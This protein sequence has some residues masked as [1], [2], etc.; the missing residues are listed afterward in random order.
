MSSSSPSLAVVRSCLDD[1]S[2]SD[3]QKDSYDD[4][5]QRRVQLTINLHGNIKIMLPNSPELGAE[6]T[7]G[8][9]HLRRPEITESDGFVRTIT[10]AE[11][12]LRNITYAR[13]LYCEMSGKYRYNADD[14]FKAFASTVL[15]GQIPIMT[16]SKACILSGLTDTELRRTGECADD[17]GGYF[18]VQSTG[19]P[20]KSI[21]AQ[22]RAACNRPFVFI[23]DDT[24]ASGR[25]VYSAEIRS[26]DPRSSR[27]QMSTLKLVREKYG[28]SI[29][30]TC[31]LPFIKDDIPVSIVL[32]ALG[33]SDIAALVCP[34]TDASRRLF[35]IAT[36][37]IPAHDQESALA[38]IG[39][40]LN[41]ASVPPVVR[42]TNLFTNDVLIHIPAH[43]ED[44]KVV[45]GEK[46]L[47]LGHSIRLLLA[48]AA[49]ERP[50]D[51]RDHLGAKRYDLAGPLMTSLF[52]QAF[53][54]LRSDLQKTMQKILEKGQDFNVEKSI[55]HGKISRFLKSSIATGNWSSRGATTARVGVTQ[56]LNRLNRASTVSQLRRLNAPS[57]RDG[58]MSKPRQLHSTQFGY[59]CPA[60]TPE[61]AQVG[62][63]KNM[64]L[65]TRMSLTSSNQG[66][67]AFI[68]E[69]LVDSLLVS[70]PDSSHTG[71]RIF[72]DGIWCGN[73]DKPEDVVSSLRQKR[74][75]QCFASDVS[76][77]YMQHDNLILIH[78]DEGR[79]IRPLFV[80][81]EGKVTALD[82]GASSTP[83]PFQTL[84]VRGLVEFVDALEEESLYIAMVPEHVTTEHTHCELHPSTILGVPASGIPYCDHNQAP[85]NT[86]Q[87]AMSKQAIGMSTTNFNERYDVKANILYYPQRP[88]ATTES[89]DVGDCSVCCVLAIACFSGYNQE[90]SLVLN[91]SSV[92]R[93]LF[94][95]YVLKTYSD[96]AS[97]HQLH[98]QEQFEIPSRDNCASIQHAN[99]TRLQADGIIAPGERVSAGDVI[100]GKTVPNL[101]VDGNITRRDAST[102]LKGFEGGIVDGVMHTTNDQGAHVVKVRIR[103]VVVPQIGDKFASRHGQKGTVGMLYRQEDM[104]FTTEGIVPDLIMNSHGI[105][106]RMTV[107]HLIEM[108]AS[109]AGVLHG[110]T[111]PA[112]AFESHDLSKYSSQLQALGFHP[113][114][115]DHMM[116]PRTG[117]RM[118][119]PYFIGVIS[120]QVLRHIVS[121][122]I[123]A[124]GPRGPVTSMVRQPVEGR[125]R[126]GGLR[127]GEMERDALISHGV[128][129]II[130]DMLHLQSDPSVV[131]ICTVCKRQGFKR[132]SNDMNTCCDKSCG[133]ETVDVGMPHASKL[134]IQ[135]MAGLGI[136]MKFDVFKGV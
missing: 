124:R 96:E 50:L 87:S 101:P 29:K 102:R 18:I 93:G 14:E 76:I 131:Q 8:K 120:Y 22:E 20:E 55:D 26:V 97:R 10:P 71:T 47:F 56:V 107:G 85:R 11:A 113:M 23:K 16:R 31:S 68:R 86:Y 88:V 109:R 117:K 34:C 39:D 79:L 108:L 32:H 24:S 129:A 52:R 70:P 106:S 116:D 4:F 7:F 82:E 51:D 128:S 12:R 77:A 75:T 123:H 43:G 30:I 42:A 36:H 125:A 110:C 115:T 6:V 66:V 104:P 73:T 28:S 19:C 35:M 53:I 94:R 80:V 13:P 21:L 61:G 81:H 119:T 132:R 41:H 134:L 57:V 100:I 84:L 33:V 60:E 27:M 44:N 112:T 74:R 133:G 69:T 92:D 58:K 127:C 99:Y 9:V 130:E 91:Q 65:L 135:E 45:F 122:K 105:P 78:S 17:L 2:L 103:T 89:V 136:S 1:Y 46:A 72:V 83:C 63:V 40:K 64:A 15:L 67:L 62:L 59:T 95:S 54:G 38:L 121:E 49:G 126:N 111:V 98:G 5:W 37:D 90:D 118:A 3:H 25:V 114:G 48:T